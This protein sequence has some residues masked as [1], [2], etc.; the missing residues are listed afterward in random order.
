MQAV[1]K[2]ATGASIICRCAFIRTQSLL[3]AI[4]TSERH[5][6]LVRKAFEPAVVVCLI[7]SVGYRIESRRH[8]Q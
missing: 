4:I 8:C 7:E 6:P 5:M 2:T 1:L 3:L